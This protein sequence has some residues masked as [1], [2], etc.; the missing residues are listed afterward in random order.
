MTIRFL[1][2]RRESLHG[3]SESYK[4]SVRD[5]LESIGF[6]QTT[7]STIQGTFQDMVFVNPISDPGKKYLIETKAEDVTLYSKK[8]ARELIHYFDL[9]QTSELHGMHFKLFAQGVIKPTLWE[10]IF[11]ENNNFVAVKEWCDWYNCKC[12]EE[13][14]SPLDEEKIKQVFEFFS[15]S[16]VIV[17]TAIDLQHATLDLQSV[18]S[19]SLTKTA[20]NLYNLVDRRKAPL[21]IQSRLVLNILPISTP[22]CYYSF[23]PTITN[24]QEIYDTL[25]SDIIPLSP[26]LLTRENRVLTFADP[27]EENPLYTIV[28][29]KIQTLNTKVLQEKNPLL[30]TE[31]VNV[32]LRRMFWNQGLYRDRKSNI[33]YFPMKDKTKDKTEVIDQRGMNRWVVKKIVRTKDTKYYK[34]GEVNFYFHRGVEVHTPTYWGESF[35]ELTPRRYYTL[36]GEKC[37]DGEIRGR[38]DRKFRNPNFDRSSARLGLM[39]FWRISYL[40]SQVLSKPKTGLESLALDL[41][42]LK[43]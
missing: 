13:N 43:Q 40:K 24:K 16:E 22:Q 5:Y 37:V 9:S 31:L 39:K 28:N 11:N 8:L 4:K 27:E 33:L 14:E 42:L 25:K 41:L 23:E 6:C 29:G 7:D 12:I 2:G 36:D 32:H 34:I 18:S 19:L 1:Y 17:G 35:V 3:K 30:S 38:I 26:F 20:S 21:P 15:K 10:S